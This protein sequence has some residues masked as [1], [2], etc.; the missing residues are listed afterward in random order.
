MGGAESC[1]FRRLVAGVASGGAQRHSRV[2]LWSLPPKMKLV[3]REAG[4][5]PW[6]AVPRTP[7][8]LFSR[9]M[10]Q[11]VSSPT[12]CPLCPLEERGGSGH[13]GCPA[14]AWGEGGAAAPTGS[15]S[16]TRAGELGP[17]TTSVCVCVCVCV[18]VSGAGCDLD[19]VPALCPTQGNLGS[20]PLWREKRE[21][22][23]LVEG[24]SGCDSHPLPS[25]KK[26]PGCRYPWVLWKLNNS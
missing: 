14:L 1:G 9:D 10:K 18:C 16:W 19:C 4:E 2:W 24:V 15:L 13:Q 26:E 17:W 21:V 11:A 20:G 8:P 22:L 7:L 3:G 6:A 12:L 23:F 5:G 25:S